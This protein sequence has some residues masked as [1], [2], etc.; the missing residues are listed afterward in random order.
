MKLTKFKGE[1]SKASEDVASQ[2]FEVLQTIIQT[3]VKFRDFAVFADLYLH[4]NKSLSFKLGNF[5][6]LRRYFQPC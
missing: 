5:T 4:H 1:T 2:S 6:D 3:S